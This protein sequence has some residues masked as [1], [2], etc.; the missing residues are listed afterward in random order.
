MQRLI[1]EPG[2]P[3]LRG[4]RMPKIR[5][6][7]TH[8]GGAHKDEL[9]ACAVLLPD[10]PVPI[11]RREPTAEDLADPGIAVVD[12]GHQ[13]DPASLNFDHHQFPAD[14]PPTCSL[15]LV[16]AHLDLYDDA[17][18]FCDWLEATEWFDCR[19]PGETAKWLEVDRETLA[20]LN[21]PIDGTLL[22]R[23][24]REN[25][26]QPG[27]PLWEFLRMIG[28]DLVDYVRSL[29]KRLDFIAANSELWDLPI[30][31]DPVRVLFLPRTPPLGPEPSFG[32][33]R[34]V[35]ASGMTSEVVGLVYPDRRGAGY[36]L[37]RFRDHGIFDFTRIADHEQVHF[38][39]ARG[40][41]AKTSATDPE[42]LQD[43]LKLAVTP[44]R[45]EPKT[46]TPDSLSLER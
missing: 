37:S 36:G 16:L 4:F 7:L 26:L 18:D 2:V 5:K 31:D 13:H 8:P 25:R 33:E 28:E 10:H 12:V 29:R 34:F 35:E 21:S 3:T 24:A 19:G 9:L 11:E 43:L 23:F 46:D 14:H 38:A 44:K 27:E 42:T 45:A 15:S 39:H 40:F 41:V 1:P 20:R 32:I 6:I 22:R 30:G 17:R